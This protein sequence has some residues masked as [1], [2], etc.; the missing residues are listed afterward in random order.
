MSAERKVQKKSTRSRPPAVTPEAQENRMISLA[1]DLA[2]ERLRNG[3]ATSQEVTHFLKLGSSKEKVEQE[4]RLEQKKL[5]KAKTEAM[6]SAKRVE[7]LYSKALDAMRTYSGSRGQE[8]ED[9]D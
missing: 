5:I 6:E 1:F 7:E 4:I 2:E 3:T 9:D 8:E